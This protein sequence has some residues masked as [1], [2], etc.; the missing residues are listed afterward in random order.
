MK[1]ISSTF[2][3]AVGVVGLP[4]VLQEL[5]GPPS[6]SGLPTWTWV[7]DGLRYQYLPVDP[8]LHAMGLLAWGLWAYTALVVVLRA[9]ALLAAR[10]QLAGSTALLAITN[11]VTVPAL[12][13][14]VD[15]A[16]GMSRLASTVTP[17]P[18]AP[19][20]VVRTV[21][22]PSEWDRA[23]P[24]LDTARAT[25]SPATPAV[26]TLAPGASWQP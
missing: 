21:E 22:A 14:V 5:V 16:V 10:R 19:A 25:P 17:P 15:A 2:G 3:L 11:L 9:V 20:A 24:L 4:V 1:R 8:L 12:R 7:R 18:P 26:S 13:S 6:L 23:R